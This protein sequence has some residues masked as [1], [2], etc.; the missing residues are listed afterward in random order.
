MPTMKVYPNGV[1]TYMGGTGTHTR[2]PR[3]DV[4]GWSAAAARR[5]RLWAWGV[6]ASALTGFGYAVTLTLKD[7]P[8][9]AVDFHVLRTTW[10]KRL[11]RMGMTRIHWVIEWQAR[12]TPHLHAAIYFPEALSPQDRAMLVG[13]WLVVSSAFGSFVWAQDLADIDGPL[14]WLKYLAKH[15]TRGVSHYQRQGHP[16]GWAKTGRLWGAGGSWPIKEPLV[17]DG[18]NL[19]EFYRLR[20][21]MRAWSF[22]DARKFG[23]TSRMKYL[24]LSAKRGGKEKSRF[25]GA[26]E[27]IPED[28]SS[29]LIALFERE[30]L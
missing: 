4:V 3:G 13:H 9:S 19:P 1:S 18:L 25:M 14:G 15:A 10:E 27:W 6:D 23:D 20:R 17:L 16:E 11:R 30:N 28:V 21:L 12:G 5:Q 7:T 8:D 24:K 29:R 2:A 26:A 22:A